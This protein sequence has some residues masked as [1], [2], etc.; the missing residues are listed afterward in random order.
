MHLTH[1]FQQISPETFEW[2][3]RWSR[4]LFWVVLGLYAYIKFATM[5]GK[6]TARSILATPPEKLGALGFWAGFDFL[7]MLAY[8]L[9][10]ALCCVWGAGLLSAGSLFYKL[11]IAL[12]WATIPLVLL[13]MAE[14]WCMWQIAIGKKSL[15]IGQAFRYLKTS[16]EWLFGATVAYAAVVSVLKW[17]NAI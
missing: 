9:F 3:M 1:P 16:K 4:I 14:N 7:F 10:F 6:N 5:P 17:T 11:G 15:A 13:D 8:T 12:A 2:L